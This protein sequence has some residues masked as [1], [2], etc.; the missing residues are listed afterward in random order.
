MFKTVLG[1]SLIA[2]ML[3]L[4]R[5]NWGV[6]GWAV[7]FSLLMALLEVCSAALVTPLITALGG[8][9]LA[10]GSGS[11]W[12]GWLTALYIPVPLHLRL[13]AVAL[14]LLLITLLKNTC[15]YVSDT[16]INQFQLQVGSTLRQQC[17]ARFL[18]LELGFYHKSNLGELLSYVSEQSQRGEQLFSRVLEMISNV[19][20]VTLLFCLLVALSPLLTLISVVSLSLVFLLLRSVMGAVQVNGRKAARSL[21]AFSIFIGEILSGLRVV[22]SYG[23][24]TAEMHSATALLQERYRTELTAFRLSSL[25]VPVTETAGIAVLL[26]LVVLGASL[27]GNS[28]LPFLLTYFMALLRI[29]PRV[30]QLSSLRSQFALLSSSLEIIQ[31][32]LDSTETDQLPDG[33]QTFSG[34]RDRLTLRNL[35]F[36]FPGST[37]LILK[38]ISLVIRRGETVALVGSSGSGKSTLVDLLMRFYDPAQG[39]IQIDGVDL[40]QFQR[41]SWRSRIAMVSQDTF[42]FNATVRENIAYG[43]PEAT[44]A[45]IIAAAQQAYADEFIQDFPLGYATVVGNRGAQLSGGQR[46]R[47]AIARAILRNPDILILDEATSALDTQSERIVQKAL[48]AVSRDRTVIVIAHRL[49]T[50]RNA[51]TIVV[52]QQ[53]R[54]IEQGM[55]QELMALQGWYSYLEKNQGLDTVNY[56]T[57][58]RS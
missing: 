38:D 4:S 1:S 58:A 13:G 42:L 24:E 45:E 10:I 50:V 27:A 11:G 7:F 22:K 52:L 55:H 8:N 40:R 37:E 5:P 39:E 32:F 47:I 17:V 21:E 48:E 34:L 30:S 26:I 29:L 25:V 43:K 12:I 28:S 31:R 16:S 14:S 20:I 57:I 15:K 18:A 36:A 2:M 46:Q 9:S 44:D 49:S 54:I 53:G 23:R 19:L 51:D 6:A 35:S 41:Q 56:S 33:I 3:N